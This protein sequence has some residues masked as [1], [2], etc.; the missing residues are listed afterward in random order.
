MKIILLIMGIGSL[1]VGLLGLLGASTEKD[2]TEY[3]ILFALYF[4][5]GIIMI[6]LGAYI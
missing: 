4:L 1:I 2:A 3:Y 6:F 5:A